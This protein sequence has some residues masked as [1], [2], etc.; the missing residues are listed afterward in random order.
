MYRRKLQ[1]RRSTVD[2]NDGS[3][4]NASEVELVRAERGTKKT[5]A[6]SAPAENTAKSVGIVQKQF[7]QVTLARYKIDPGG[8]FQGN[9]GP[10][11]NL[12]VPLVS[13]SFN[14]FL[15]PL[16]QFLPRH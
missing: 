4:M 2:F 11:K 15:A 7:L 16:L 14:A 1:S 6:Q 12:I 8:S 13:S 5:F 3:S 9:R 10:L